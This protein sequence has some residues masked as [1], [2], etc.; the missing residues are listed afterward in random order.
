MRR[1]PSQ[2][3]HADV[4]VLRRPVVERVACWSARHRLIALVAWLAMVGGALLAGHAYGT[5]HLAQYDP[6]PSGTATR[7]TST[8]G[9]LESTAINVRGYP[10][11]TDVL[12]AQASTNLLNE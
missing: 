2:S 7:S 3:R 10:H 4:P 6:G 12:G 9:A 1:L 8:C 11:R 5:A